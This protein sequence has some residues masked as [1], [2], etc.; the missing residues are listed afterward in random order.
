MEW[1][2]VTIGLWTFAGS[3]LFQGLLRKIQIMTRN[4]E[5]AR[6][7]HYYHEQSWVVEEEARPNTQAGGAFPFS[8]VKYVRRQ[9]NDTKKSDSEIHM[10]AFFCN[11]KCAV[12]TLL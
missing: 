11:H 12:P 5:T 2:R 4:Y 3:G 1:E 9:Q 6:E 7:N 10:N 8:Y